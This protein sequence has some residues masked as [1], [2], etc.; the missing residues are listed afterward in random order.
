MLQL[1]GAD[2]AQQTCPKA[3]H[4]VLLHDNGQLRQSIYEFLKVRE[5]GSPTT[6]RPGGSPMK[7]SSGQF[8]WGEGDKLQKSVA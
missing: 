2:L 6:A 5:W 8:L 4:D 1:G 7:S 3:L